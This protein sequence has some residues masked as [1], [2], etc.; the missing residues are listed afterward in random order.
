MLT[1]RDF[2][3]KSIKGKW[4]EGP[5]FETFDAAVEAANQ[6]ITS[7]K[8]EVVQIETVSLPNIHASGETGSTDG[9]LGIFAGHASWHQFLRI[10]YRR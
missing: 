6:W 10:W 2:V 1:Y 3:P 9:E 8:I 4:Y 7:D 5:A